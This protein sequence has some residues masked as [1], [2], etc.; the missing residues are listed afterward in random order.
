MTIAVTAANVRPI[1]DYISVRV[2]S[3]GTLTAGMVVYHNGTGLAAADDDASTASA[4]CIGIL[5]QDAASGVYGD[6]LTIGR[7]TGW[8]GLTAGTIAY[9]SDTG[10]VA[11]SAGT[12][13]FAVGHML[14]TTDILVHPF[15]PV[16]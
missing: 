14:S 16:A 8:T 12:K 7:V 11:A 5:L 1:G 10:V 13:N 15:A 6:V 4:N 2:V 3:N 9:V